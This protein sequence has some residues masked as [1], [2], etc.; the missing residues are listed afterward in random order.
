MLRLCHHEKSS[1]PT[2]QVPPL[3]FHGTL[4]DQ[5][6]KTNRSA[7]K[8]VIQTIHRREVSLS[9][10]DLPQNRNVPRGFIDFALFQPR[11]T[12]RQPS[13]TQISLS[14]ATRGTWQFSDDIAETLPRAFR[15]DRIKKFAL[16]GFRSPDSSD[17]GVQTIGWN[18]RA[19]Q[20]LGTF[21]IS[22]RFC[23]YNGTA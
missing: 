2:P 5:L 4:H 6:T 23:R 22:S 18:M 20:P 11:N 12:I 1:E 9:S 14:T 21:L 7:Y 19:E 10:L 15:I 3:I 16:R 8:R 13:S 17:H